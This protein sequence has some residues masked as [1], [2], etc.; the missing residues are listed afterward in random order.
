LYFEYGSKRDRGGLDFYLTRLENPSFSSNFAPDF[1]QSLKE[2][3]LCEEIKNEKLDLEV[4]K[5]L[6]EF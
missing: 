2:L 5:N 3:R 1:E 4:P 6:N